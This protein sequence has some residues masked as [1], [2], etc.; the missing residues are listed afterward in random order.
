MMWLSEIFQVVLVPYNKC[1]KFEE[2]D[3]YIYQE[4]IDDVYIAYVNEM[5][6]VSD[7]SSSTHRIEEAKSKD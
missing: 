4:T 3:I 1:Y 5:A 2:S 7:Y 6:E